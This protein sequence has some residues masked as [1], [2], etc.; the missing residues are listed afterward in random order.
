MGILGYDLA[1]H[2]AHPKRLWVARKDCNDMLGN[3][4]K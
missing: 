4:E 2:K 1:Y 3:L